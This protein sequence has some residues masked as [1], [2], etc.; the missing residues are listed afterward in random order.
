MYLGVKLSKVLREQVGTKP[1]KVG[2]LGL[3][4]NSAKV[5]RFSATEDPPPPPPPPPAPGP[6][7]FAPWA[8]QSVAK[9][10]PSP[11]EVKSAKV[12]PTAL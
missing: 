10:G 11:G 2:R 5:R 12:R 6:Q 9:V 7:V 8:D 3:G 1:A 4:V